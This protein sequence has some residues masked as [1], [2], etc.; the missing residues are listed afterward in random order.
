M[1][2]LEKEQMFCMFGDYWFFA[3]CFFQK[4]EIIIISASDIP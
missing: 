1:A 3:K 2:F 4:K